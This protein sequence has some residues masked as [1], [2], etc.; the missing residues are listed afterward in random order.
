MSSE[1]RLGVMCLCLYVC[2]CESVCDNVCVRA[3]MYECV[4]VCM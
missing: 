3:W 2:E 4:C 1:E